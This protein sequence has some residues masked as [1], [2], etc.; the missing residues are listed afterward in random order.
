MSADQRQPEMA[1]SSEVNHDRRCYATIYTPP[2][3]PDLPVPA[4]DL[5][6]FS[7]NGD[8]YRWSV[9]DTGKMQLPIAA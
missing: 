8:D 4:D 1:R 7:G 3:S 2:K 9:L 5:A 6:E